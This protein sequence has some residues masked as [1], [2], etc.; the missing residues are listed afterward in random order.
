MVAI[1]PVKFRSKQAWQKH[2][3]PGFEL[4]KK[5][6]DF[7][8]Q[9]TIPGHFPVGFTGARSGPFVQTLDPKIP[10]YY[11]ATNYWMT[12]PLDI[13]AQ[14][15]D[16]PALLADI[17]Y[18][19]LSANTL[20]EFGS[21]ALAV[22][23]DKLKHLWPRLHRVLP[24]NSGTQATDAALKWATS[25]VMLR[26]HLQPQDMHFVACESAFHGR[27][28]HGIEGTRTSHRTA[29]YQTGLALRIPNPTV[30]YDK[31]GQ[32]LE[33]E[34]TQ[35]VEEALH[36]LKIHFQLP[37][38][39]ALILEYPMIAEGGAIPIAP[40]FLPA[41]RALCDQYAKFLIIDCVQMFGKS[42]NW[43]TREAMDVADAICI[44]KYS[45]VCA[46]LFTDPTLKQYPD[47]AGTPGKFGAT[48]QGH[49]SAILS[50]IAIM[51]LVEEKHLFASAVSLAN[52]FY[53][54]L[55]NLAKADRGIVRPR[56]SGTYVGFDL[57]AGS[58]GR[59]RLVELMQE[60][61]VLILSAGDESIRFAPRLDTQEWEI[62][63]LL[64]HLSSSLHKLQ[65]DQK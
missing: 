26:E 19:A 27:C 65:E 7:V 63:Y 47:Y 41:A 33:K 31:L 30:V 14:F 29:D 52:Q 17:G 28:G 2:L 60:D 45:R 42:G 34:T 44:G 64:E 39:S 23:V 16:N 9:Y 6:A 59:D 56:I 49:E 4:L 22:I 36:Q 8:D 37:T 51:D 62:E 35:K 10:I 40:A 3:D 21:V 1:P 18:A 24:Y 20:S 13:E 58:P 61:G 57:A 15:G 55:V 5:N 53:S 12:L 43:L 54:S 38:T 46:A 11:D 50:T 25:L 48:W 32:V